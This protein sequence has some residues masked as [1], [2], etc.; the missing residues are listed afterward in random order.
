LH[1]V[2]S[3]FRIAY[4][5][6][7]PSDDGF[8][9]QQMQIASVRVVGVDDP[10][11]QAAIFS[12]LKQTISKFFEFADNQHM[13]SGRGHSHF[14]VVIGDEELRYVNDAGQPLIFVV[15]ASSTDEPV[16]E[17]ERERE[18]QRELELSSAP[19][20][21]INADGYL[22]IR[23]QGSL[24]D[25]YETVG[26]IYGLGVF[27]PNLDDIGVDGFYHTPLDSSLSA[28]GKW[29]IAWFQPL[30]AEAGPYFDPFVFVGS[31]AEANTLIE[32][33]YM[34]DGIL[35]GPDRPYAYTIKASDFQ[36]V[37]KVFRLS[38]EAMGELEFVTLNGS[39]LVVASLTGSLLQLSHEEMGFDIEDELHYTTYRPPPI[40][41]FG[42]FDESG[43]RL[44]KESRCTAT[45]TISGPDGLSASAVVELT[46]EEPWKDV[47]VKFGPT[48]L[49]DPVP[50]QGDFVR[51]GEPR[52]LFPQPP[53]SRNYL[54]A[55][56]HFLPSTE[57]NTFA[58]RPLDVLGNPWGAV[59]ELG[60][61]PEQLTVS[62]TLSGDSLGQV[63]VS[64]SG[65]FFARNIVRNVVKGWNAYD[66]TGNVLV[67]DLPVSVTLGSVQLSAPVVWGYDVTFNTDPPE[68]RSA[69][70]TF[71]LGAA[72]WSDPSV[73][74]ADTIVALP[75]A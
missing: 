18:R 62:V 39:G 44:Y 57:T 50:D 40:L 41:P 21:D 68:K 59:L 23:L 48:A 24:R 26:A 35:G 46:K 15:P 47:M 4:R 9:S 53:G 17:R 36:Q 45:I 71:N 69:T 1:S 54:P 22:V 14:R 65:E 8:V 72:Q 16:V 13:L 42:G 6:F 60:S 7:A 2:V 19:T 31:G 70:Y 12:R 64:G 33:N 25:A 67:T 5:P 74:E 11:A 34:G 73:W 51:G 32:A 3:D 27:S 56:D 63:S 10:E 20:L 37:L 28:V 61:A 43:N 75:D 29:W 52:P 38:P 30:L 49:Y 58:L 55:Y 66:P